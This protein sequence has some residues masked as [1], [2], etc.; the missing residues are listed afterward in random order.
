MSSN[1]TIS[2]P[3]LPR[4]THNEGTL[5]TSWSEV[6]AASVTPEKR[7]ALIVQNKD[8]SI[9][10]EIHLGSSGATAAGG[11]NLAPGASISLDSYKGAVQAR[12]A[13]GT[14]VLHVAYGII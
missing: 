13:S 5:T 1:I 6:L 8:A 4:F 10:V 14:P 7:V 11:L 3:F 12:S 2:S 9:A